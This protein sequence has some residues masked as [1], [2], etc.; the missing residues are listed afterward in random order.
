MRRRRHPDSRR[1]I[2]N[3]LLS[4]HFPVFDNGV[5]HVA[6]MWGG[7]GFGFGD[8]EG[9]EKQQWF[10]IYNA[11]PMRFRGLAAEAHADV[12]IANHPVLDNTYANLAALDARQP[13]DPNPWVVGEDSVQG[14]VTTAAEC[15]AAAA[16]DIN[17]VAAIDGA[18]YDGMTTSSPDSRK[19]DGL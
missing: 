7:T 12:L 10:E 6:A 15:A 1:R 16:S 11:S 19:P 5:R 17:G 2:H 9:R 4:F 18:D 14:Y 3:V 13:G 8:A